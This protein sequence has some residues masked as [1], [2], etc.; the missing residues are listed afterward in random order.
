MRRITGIVLAIAAAVGFWLF[1]WPQF[2]PYA[3][4][5]IPLLGDNHIAITKVEPGPKGTWDITVSYYYN[6]RPPGARIFAKVSGGPDAKE[7]EV[8]GGHS[9]VTLPG[10]RTLQIH[11][12][13]PYSKDEI[14][15]TKV[16]VEIRSPDKATAV[17]SATADA[18]IGWADWETYSIG[19]E[20]SGYPPDQ[21]VARASALAGKGDMESVIRAKGILQ[22]LLARYPANPT[23]SAEL[24]R[25]QSESIWGE[26]GVRKLNE[27]RLLRPGIWSLLN[28]NGFEELDAMEESL[29]RT[30]AADIDGYPMLRLYYA[31]LNHMLSQ[32]EATRP[33][34][35]AG[36]EK[37]YRAWL[38]KRPQ[39]V[40]ARLALVDM[41]ATLALNIRLLNNATPEQ[42]GQFRSYVKKAFDELQACD[43]S[44]CHEDP[45]W[46]FQAVHLLCVSSAPR[47]AFGSAFSDAYARFPEYRPIRAA[48]S[49]YLLANSNDGREYTDFAQQLAAKAPKEVADAVYTQAVSDP[50]G[51]FGASFGRPTPAELGLDCRRILRGHEQWLTKYPSPANWN[52]AASAAAQCGD[53]TATRH[54]LEHVKEPVLQ[55]WGRG[56]EPASREFARVKAWAG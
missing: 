32:E 27:Y 25:I 44:G 17:V 56:T 33:E 21:V 34:Q 22:A 51:G 45:E 5:Y 31:G 10:D 13:R 55:Q 20:V 38:Q 46:H 37:V 19:R 23:A 42:L 2:G 9:L 8:V 18:K 6:N 53:K 26:A 48:A 35:G 29:R 14:K 54:F 1:A 50:L 47:G 39:S 24:V 28:Y 3:M 7:Y 41:Y 12:E 40:A 15:A 4:E 16:T 49:C 11:A 30:S 43:S 52:R 36:S